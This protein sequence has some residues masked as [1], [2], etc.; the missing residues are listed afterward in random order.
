[1]TQRTTTQF[2]GGGKGRGKGPVSCLCQQCQRR[3]P[4]ADSSELARHMARQLGWFLAGEPI[5][6]TVCPICRSRGPDPNL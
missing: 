2:P 4:A 5:I 6:V 3:G 1:M